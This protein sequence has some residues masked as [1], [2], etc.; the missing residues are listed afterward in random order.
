M[1]RNIAFITG[2]VVKWTLPRLFQLKKTMKRQKDWPLNKTIPSAEA[3]TELNLKRCS[4][5]LSKLI[6]GNYT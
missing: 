3:E 6:E 2:N 5:I 4:I 1:M